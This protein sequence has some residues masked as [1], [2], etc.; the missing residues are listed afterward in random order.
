MKPTPVVELD[1][2]SFVPLYHQLYE[3]LRGQLETGVYQPGD[4][5]PTEAE[6]CELY[7]V[8]QITIR[9]ALNML[10]DAGLIYRRKGKGTFV[11][12]PAITA[13][14]R[15]L[16]SFEED[17]RQRGLAH[18]TDVLDMGTAA[19]SQHTAQALKVEIGEE[20]VYVS[21]LRYAEGDPLCV[22]RTSILKKVCPDLL[23]HDLAAEPLMEIL[24]RQYGIVLTRALQTIRARQAGSEYAKL[25]N[26]APED[27]LLVVERVVYSQQDQAI[28]F[29]RI[30][31]RGDRYALH[32]ELN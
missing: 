29:A 23:R 9:Q 16:I 13:S 32:L 20:V 12:K 30:F 26:I 11:S 21:R 6:L 24:R 8:S 4:R 28:Q 14:L 25:L 7:S 2:N 1:R 3:A 19:V 5:I 17:M 15:K 18:H 22:E 27:P 31:Y 10:V